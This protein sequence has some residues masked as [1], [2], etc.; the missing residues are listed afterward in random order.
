LN[1]GEHHL[2]IYNFGVHVAPYGDPA[3]NGFAL[4]E[5]LN[6]EAAV[7]A[8]GYVGRS[9]YDGEPGPESWGVQTF[10]RYLQG[11][12]HESGPSS[13]SLWQDIECLMAF[14]Y[15]GIHAEALKHARCWNV[16]QKWP[17]LVLFWVE[18]GQRPVWAEAV[19]RFERLADDGPSSAAFT[20]KQP[21]DPEG[22][23]YLIDRARV[24][25]ISAEN[26]EG[27]ADLMQIVLGL[28]A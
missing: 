9:G 20:F 7:R 4:R 11:S 24:K 18:A 19:S 25:A 1:G 26:A 14:S 23:P 13:L 28:P 12:G 8:V 2:A 3:V 21:Y 6:F 15:S 17:P 16:P 5:P 27:Q 10:P 22:R